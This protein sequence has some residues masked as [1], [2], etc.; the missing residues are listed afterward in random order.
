[1]RSAC[2]VLFCCAVVTG[3]A[4]SPPSRSDDVCR[5]FYEK[6]GWYEA[7]LDAKRRHGTPVDLQMA[8]IKQESDFQHDVRPREDGFLGIF[9]GRTK[10]S[11]YGY[12]QAIDST[13]RA[14]VDDTGVR[15]A[16]RDVFYD[17]VDFVAWYSNQTRIRSGIGFND[18]YNQYLN[19]HEGWGGYSR[20][21]HASKAW[22]LAVADKVTHNRTRYAQQMQRC[23]LPPAGFWRRVV[24]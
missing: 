10:S 12:S 21:T 19:Y 7:A 1:M 9:P 4:T 6:R 14:Y 22:L 13:W 11:A 16:R 8:I 20:N 17:A 2:V 24:G 15:G 3:C 18:T 23:V 5:I